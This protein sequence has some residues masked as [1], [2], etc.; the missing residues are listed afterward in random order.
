MVALNE[1]VEAHLDM[2]RLWEVALIRPAIDCGLRG[3]GCIT[4]ITAVSGLGS[5]ERL[6]LGWRTLGHWW[7]VEE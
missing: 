2:V 4:W 1:D 7:T 3:G 6:F 5:S